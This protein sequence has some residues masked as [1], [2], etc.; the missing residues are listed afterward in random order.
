[1][2]VVVYNKTKPIFKRIQKDRF[3]LTPSSIDVRMV[4]GILNNV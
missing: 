2:N 4:I 3:L 1:M